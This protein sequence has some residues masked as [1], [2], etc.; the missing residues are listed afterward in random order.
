ME[1]D[2]VRRHVHAALERETRINLHHHSIRSK[3]R[4][5]P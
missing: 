2:A 5:E 1:K 3:L 4:T